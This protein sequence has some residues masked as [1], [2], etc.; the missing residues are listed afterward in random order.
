MTLRLGD[1][2]VIPLKLA[3]DHWDIIILFRLFIL[4]LSFPVLSNG[5]TA[6]VIITHV[7]V[8]TKV[9]MIMD[10]CFAVTYNFVIIQ[11]RSISVQAAV[12]IDVKLRPRQKH[13]VRRN[14]RRD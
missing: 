12:V 8:C 3:V 14:I 11:P 5:D 1:I 4:F 6:L 13:Y 9:D 10:I 7:V 2:K